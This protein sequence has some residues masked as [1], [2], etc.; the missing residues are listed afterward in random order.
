MSET[1]HK[2]AIPAIA[3]RNA[4]RH[5]DSKPEPYAI[6]RTGNGTYI[7]LTVDPINELIAQWAKE[8]AK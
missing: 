8:K 4:F 5:L 7:A 3:V 2:T 1:P 6:I